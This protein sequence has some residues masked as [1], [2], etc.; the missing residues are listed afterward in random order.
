MTEQSGPQDKRRTSR[1][2]VGFDLLYKVAGEPDI[3]V[4]FGAQE[5]CTHMF[6]L[7]EG[8][9]AI[10]TSRPLAIGTEMD[11]TFHVIFKEGQTPPM[12]ARARVV[13][14]QSMPD[15]KKYRLGIQFSDIRPEDRE[16]VT[17]LVRVREEDKKKKT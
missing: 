1:V 14:C 13:Y 9:M 7:S 4:Q 8:G 2:P 6:D 5:I 16:Y 15:E 11:I 12:E 17:E 10:W 3:S